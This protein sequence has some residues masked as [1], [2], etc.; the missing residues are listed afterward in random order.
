MHM[1]PCVVLQFLI[2]MVL[3]MDVL[4]PR[5]SIGP[6][7]PSLAPLQR[8]SLFAFYFSEFLSGELL[9]GL[10]LSVETMVIRSLLSPCAVSQKPK[11]TQISPRHRELSRLRIG[12]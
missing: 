12:H 3:L 7:Q 6:A 2:K 11:H 9:L 10:W 5:R 8:P 4:P 1:P